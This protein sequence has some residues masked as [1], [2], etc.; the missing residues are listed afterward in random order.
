MQKMT[1]AE[2]IAKTLKQYDITHVFYI[3]AMLRRTLVEMEKLGIKR[4]L[5][6]GEK[7][8][9]YMS[10]GYARAKNSPSVCMA[11]SVGAANLAAGLQDAYLGHSPVIA[12]TG[13]K[14]PV[15]Q[16]RRSYQEIDHNIMFEPVTKYNCRIDDIQQLPYMLR[17][18]FKAATS[19]APQPVHIDI[20][21]YEGNL[22]DE[23]ISEFDVIYEKTFAT[24]PAFRPTPEKKFV[25]QA[26]DA[27]L[28]AEKPVVV[29][30][31]GVL[32]SEAKKVFK[33]FVELLPIPVASSVDGKTILL[34][35]HPLYVGP[36]GTYSRPCANKIVQQ[37][38]L[39]FFIGTTVSDQVT[40]NWT[41]PAEG[42]KIIQLDIEAF[43]PGRNYAQT[44]CLHGDVRTTLEML[45]DLMPKKKKFTEWA[46]EC[47]EL[48]QEWWQKVDELRN[49]QEVPITPERLCREITDTL[50]NDAILVADT[51]YSAIWAATQINFHH[52][53]QLMLRAAGSLGWA[54]PAA[55][56]VKCAKPSRPVICFTGDGAFWYHLQEMETADRWGINTVTVVNNNSILGQSVLGINKAYRD[57]LGEKEHMYKYSCTDFSAIAEDMGCIGIRVSEPDEIGNTI[58]K[59]LEMDKPVI[60]D[61]TT[62]GF[63]YPQ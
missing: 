53:D 26:I 50:P 54:F 9:A 60:V 58:K 36:V 63:V 23:C 24:I 11:Q 48:V 31:R 47:G 2:Y 38:D 3:E 5:T 21:G 1:G 34:D 8:A 6:H 46:S 22:T 4:I 18:A 40:M 59:A 43:E 7:A 44:I 32:L 41:L 14:P 15:Q 29:A 49:S 61:V 27:L 30:G 25:E 33:E 52:E 35:D 13:R 37:A 55:L 17:H 56:G 62:K 39:V 10:D 16:Y 45:I 57:D 19:G 51:G 42:K 20:L 28:K 12:L